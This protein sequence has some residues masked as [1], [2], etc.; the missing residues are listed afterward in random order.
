LHSAHL[1][2]VLAK[3]LNV[4]QA[5]CQTALWSDELEH[6]AGRCATVIITGWAR[7][8]ARA[9][10]LGLAEAGVLRERIELARLPVRGTDL[11]H[12][13]QHSED[14][15]LEA[16]SE[17]RLFLRLWRIYLWRYWRLLLTLAL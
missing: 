12:S 11:L 9:L 14:L 13:C 10:R 7:I 3:R 2:A 16:L 17:L 8:I 4:A 5:L 6:G 1:P 15:M